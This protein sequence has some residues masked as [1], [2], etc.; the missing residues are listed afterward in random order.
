MTELQNEELLLVDGGAGIGKAIEAF[1][2]SLGIANALAI[3][4]LGGPL[5]GV[6]PAG[7]VIT[8]AGT[9]WTGAG[10]FA[11]GTMAVSSVGL[12]VRGFEDD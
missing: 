5:L 2:A 9:A 7:G 6:A 12:I 1:G 4:I 8:A 10:I 3:G 11:G